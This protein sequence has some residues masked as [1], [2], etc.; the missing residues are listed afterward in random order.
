MKEIQLT[1]PIKNLTGDGE[2]TSI[3]M[4]DESEMDAYD[5]YDVCF[6]SDG[7]VSIGAMSPAI[8]NL[9]NLTS[10]QVAS[11]HIK[12]FMKLSADLGKY[13]M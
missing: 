3:K 2:L 4:K 7:K 10:E 11:L 5:F 8:A 13:I 9:C 1:R 6:G 12:D